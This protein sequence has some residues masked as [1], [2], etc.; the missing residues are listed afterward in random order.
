MV[1]TTA[2]M[3]TR[4]SIMLTLMGK[5]SAL[6]REVSAP[7]HVLTD[8]PQSAI[9][10]LSCKEFSLKLVDLAFACYVYG[11]LSNY[12][13]SY[14]RFLEAT[15]RY[16]N[17]SIANH[18]QAL[19]KWLNEWGCRQFALKYH[20]HASKE[21]L[22]WHNSITSKLVPRNRTLLDM[23]GNELSCAE[24]AYQSLSE[25]IASYRVVNGRRSAVSFGP[26]GASKVLFAIRPE[27][28]VPWDISIRDR[29]GVPYGEFLRKVRSML[30]ELETACQKHG[31]RLTDL[32]NRLKRP[33]STLAK[34][35]DE[36]Y[37]ITITYNC[38]APDPETIKLWSEWGN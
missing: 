7:Y 18:R 8:K 5:K 26:T 25:R 13:D 19:L 6:S 22:S 33:R 17:L 10:I 34:L 37:W 29:F 9:L 1:P 31:L 21:L 32:P 38:P 24:E 15:N 20:E 23:T 3:L 27:A 4:T 16:P 11:Q 2:E 30:K 35:I 36:Y 12:D 28:F 14:V